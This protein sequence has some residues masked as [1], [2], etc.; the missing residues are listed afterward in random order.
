MEEFNEQD[1]A[2]LSNVK[3]LSR[4]YNNPKLAVIV[5]LSPSMSPSVV[6][7]RNRGSRFD[8]DN[9]D[10]INLIIEFGYKGGKQLLYSQIVN[11]G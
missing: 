9:P 1:L 4:G 11:G 8:K 3:I 2:G 6:E 7:Q 5:N 10:K